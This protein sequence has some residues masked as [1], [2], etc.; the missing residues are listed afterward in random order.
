M[1]D[2]EAGTTFVTDFAR[3]YPSP[4]GSARFVENAFNDRY[5]PPVE[6]AAG[7]PFPVS[8]MTW[9]DPTLDVDQDDQGAGRRVDEPILAGRTRFSE[10]CLEAAVRDGVTQCVILSPGF[11]TF[12]YRRPDLLSSLNIFELDQ[13][14][15]QI[16]KRQRLA[17]AGLS[18]PPQLTLLPYDFIRQTL[19]GVLLASSYHL[20]R[21]AFFSWFGITY[22]LSK[23]M[24]FSTL[25]DMRSVAEPGSSIVF[26]YVDREA[27]IAQNVPASN[28]LLSRV[29]QIDSQP[30]RSAF[31]PES[32]AAELWLVG[33]KLAENLT[34]KEVAARYSSAGQ[35]SP[36]PCDHIHFA[37]AVCV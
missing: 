37:R 8:P 29:N 12:A 26:D 25:A 15:V 24:I 13:P 31:D 14:S 19:P 23:E 7:K 5:F 11:D 16:V 33:L 30:L 28:P 18:I 4:L 36:F 22:Y 20:A 9:V 6:P 32:L 34:P 2:Y 27:L 35:A 3:A 10:D 21:P 1:T 17:A